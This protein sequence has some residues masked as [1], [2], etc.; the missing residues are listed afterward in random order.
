TLLALS[1]CSFSGD[2]QGTGGDKLVFDFTDPTMNSASSI[3][4]R[5]PDELI[6]LSDGYAVNRVHE[7]VTVSGVDSEDSS[8]C[9]VEYRFNY[10]DDGLDSLLKYVEDKVSDSN[11]TVEESM[12]NILTGEP[13]ESIE[14]GED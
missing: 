11:G 6:G 14:L 4:F 1:A 12:A 2:S 9:A 13:L 10:A 8:L 7:A 5:I 3:E